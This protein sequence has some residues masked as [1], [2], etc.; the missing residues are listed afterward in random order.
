MQAILRSTRSP[1]G[2]N[3]N[4]SNE[5]RFYRTDAINSVNNLRFDPVPFSNV[6]FGQEFLLGYLTYTNAAWIIGSQTLELDIQTL[7]NV[8]SDPSYTQFGQF[9]LTLVT[10]PDTGTAVQNADFMYFQP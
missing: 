5:I 1:A 3:G 2:G 7:G 4:N 8:T 9:L 10:T 6:Q